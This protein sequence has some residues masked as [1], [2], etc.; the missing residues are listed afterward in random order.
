MLC[1]FCGGKHSSLRCTSYKKFSERQ[2]R[3]RNMKLC[4]RCLSSK[5]LVE[6]CVS[7]RQGLPFNCSGCQSSKLVSP[8]CP[9]PS[10]SM[11]SGKVRSMKGEQL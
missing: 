6:D 10:V 8:M 9:S 3:A 1:K 4:T 7:L 11:C 2:E 5:H